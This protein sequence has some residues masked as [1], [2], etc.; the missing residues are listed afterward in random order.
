MKVSAAIKYYGTQ[1]ALAEALGVTQPCVS[2]WVKREKIPSLQQLRLQSITKDKL[3]A[4][5]SITR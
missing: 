1:T 4:D 2:N 5:R 3:K